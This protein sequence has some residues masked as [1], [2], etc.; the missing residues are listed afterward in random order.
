VFGKIPIEITVKTE[1]E[2]EGEIAR[3]NN[4]RVLTE[5]V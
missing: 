1:I 3:E 2:V 4:G 5:E